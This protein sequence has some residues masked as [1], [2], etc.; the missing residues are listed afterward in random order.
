VNCKLFQ[1]FVNRRFMILLKVC[2]SFS[3]ILSGRDEKIKATF[4]TKQ[5]V[6][7]AELSVSSP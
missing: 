7:I 3:F 4:E 5:C 2:A 6:K 1:L